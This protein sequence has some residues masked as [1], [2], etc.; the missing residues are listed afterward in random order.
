MRTP[1][2]L[3]SLK[4][5][6]NQT[7]IRRHEE[8]VATEQDIHFHRPEFNAGRVNGEKLRWSLFSALI[9]KE[10]K[11]RVTNIVNDPEVDLHRESLHGDKALKNNN[12]GSFSN[13]QI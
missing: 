1:R 12:S 4:I 5:A 13:K 10:I 11:S 9:R 2:S 6:P 3:K 8:T 7:T